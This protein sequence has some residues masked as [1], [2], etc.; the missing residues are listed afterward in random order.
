MIERDVFINLCPACRAHLAEFGAGADPLVVIPT[1]T[2]T[3]LSALLLKVG[4]RDLSAAEAE[5]RVRLLLALTAE[6]RR[7]REP[8][9]AA[10][11]ERWRKRHPGRARR[12]FGEGAS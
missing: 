4:E 12:L 7:L 3:K 8:L 6:A 10:E 1:T 5:G 11:L 9:V 2:A